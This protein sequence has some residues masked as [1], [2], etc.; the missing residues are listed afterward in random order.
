MKPIEFEE[1]NDYIGTGKDKI[2]VNVMNGITL[3]RWGM[4]WRERFSILWHGKIWHVVYGDTM[5]KTLISGT[6]AFGIENPPTAQPED[7]PE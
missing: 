6:Q 3:S 7:A 5:Q 4:T 2:P 1:A